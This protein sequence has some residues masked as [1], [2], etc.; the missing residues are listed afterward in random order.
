MPSLVG[1]ELNSS[2]PDKNSY[3]E[4]GVF[5]F[6]TIIVRFCGAVP[7]EEPDLASSY[8][9]RVATQDIIPIQ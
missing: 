4:K 5:I 2:P 8:V 9:N 7:C 3:F 6:I 1:K